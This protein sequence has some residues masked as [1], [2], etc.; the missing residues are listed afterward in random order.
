MLASSAH[1][2]E[3]APLEAPG[4]ERVI[5]HTVAGDMVLRLYPGAA[6][7]TVQQFLELVRSGA[8]D[9]TAFTRVHPGFF[10]QTSGTP[11]KH[12]TPA[13]LHKLPLEASTLIHERGV[14][15]MTREANDPNSGEMSFCILL[16]PAPHLDGKY[17]IFGRVETGENVLDELVKVPRDTQLRP[18]IRLEIAR[19]EVVSSEQLAQAHVV[20]AHRVP[21]TPG[22][23]AATAALFAVAA[24]ADT[25]TGSPLVNPMLIGVLL[26]VVLGAA[27]ALLRGRVADR[28]LVSLNLIGVLVGAF[29]LFVALMPEAQHRPLLATALLLGII[30]V[31]KL[32]GRFESAAEAP[33]RPGG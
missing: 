31:F 19:A 15:S 17:T 27:I 3:K 29:L 16:G 32:L 12:A 18:A 14:L 8:Y 13:T 21:G 2:A 24:P 9:G 25:Q 20:A 33:R 23:D 1:A 22:S 4:P 5:L 26:M 11:G 28:V 6:P 30:G 10:V 7:Q